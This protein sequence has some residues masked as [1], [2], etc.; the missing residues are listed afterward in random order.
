MQNLCGASGNK[1]IGIAILMPGERRGIERHF[2]GL[3]VEGKLE[4]PCLVL[5]AWFSSDFD[6]PRKTRR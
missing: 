6:V 2:R 3:G 5:D 4:F 1:N